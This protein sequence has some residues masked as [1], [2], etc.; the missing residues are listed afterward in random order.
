MDS[1][2]LRENS[3]CIDGGIDAKKIGGLDRDWIGKKRPNPEGGARQR[4]DIGAYEF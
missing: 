2:A 3:L 4:Y 1:L